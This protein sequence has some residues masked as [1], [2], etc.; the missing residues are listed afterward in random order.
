MHNASTFSEEA[1][2]KAEA[3]KNADVMQKCYETHSLILQKGNDSGGALEYYKKHL[4]IRDS[5]LVERR[6]SE[7]ERNKRIA[8]LESSE[9]DIKIKI[10]DEEVKD[11]ALKQAKSEAK[12]RE[13][14]NELLRRENEL[15]DLEKEKA[16]Q[17]LAIAKHRH[18]ALLREKQIVSLEKEKEIKDLMLKHKEAEEKEKQRE[19]ELLVTQKEK[20][21]LTIDKQ[22]EKEKGFQ[23]VL[24]LASII[25]LLIIFVLIWF[26][27]KNKILAKQKQEIAEKNEKLNQKNEEVS[28]QKEELAVRNVE[29]SEKNDELQQRNEE[30]S[31]QKDELA[32]QKTHLQIANNEIERKNVEI[33]DSI[34]YAERIQTAVLPPIDIL[35]SSLKDYFIFYKP[36]DIVSGDFYWIKRIDDNIVIA[37]ADCTGHGVPGA[38]MSMLGVSLLNEIVTKTQFDNAGKTLDKLR[39]KVKT[40]LRQTGKKTEQKDGMDMV[41][42][43]LDTDNMKLQYAGA[44]NPLY[45][46]RDNEPI[47]IKGDKMPIGIHNKEKPFTNHVINI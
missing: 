25:I 2:E 31:S 43:I 4:T 33:T 18:D 41:L 37:I 6:L 47:L 40:S 11:L 30:I 16:I 19:I 38:F 17:Q 5:L 26:R 28:A 27:R 39:K 46:I 34:R 42:Y 44:N 20:Q 24:A 15:K 3:S 12:R 8:E 23:R 13:Q 14:E 10:A 21:Q 45:L 22:Y 7:N 1:V 29:I 35:S 9:Q 36:R 32:A